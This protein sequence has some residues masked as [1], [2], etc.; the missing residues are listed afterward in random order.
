MGFAAKL[1]D[2]HESNPAWQR[3]QLVYVVPQA[4]ATVESGSIEH[5]KDQCFGVGA[6]RSAGEAKR[7]VV[8]DA[9]RK[10]YGFLGTTEFSIVGLLARIF[11]GYWLPLVFRSGPLG[12]WGG[13]IPQ[14]SKL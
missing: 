6:A 3:L 9:G 1:A 11:S 12:G 10:F 13:C 8:F 5:L 2:E 14:T 7:T 4:P